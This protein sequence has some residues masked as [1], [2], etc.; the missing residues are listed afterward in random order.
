VEY[1]SNGI[2]VGMIAPKLSYAPTGRVLHAGRLGH[3]KNVDV[4][5]RAFARLLETLPDYTLDIVGD[6]PAR[7]NL[8]RL[9]RSLGIGQNVRMRGFMDR[10]S[11][12]RA[13]RDYDAFVTASTIE[14]QGIVLLEAMAAGLPVVGVD[15]LAIPEIVRDGRSGRIVAPGDEA[16]IA[17]ALAEVLGDQE[18]RARMGA[19]GREDVQPHLLPAVVDHLEELYGQVLEARKQ[20]R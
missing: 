7:P 15:A 9:I 18:A 17:T 3:E 11:L 13:Y 2:D 1:L 5:L 20:S 19:A 16:G 6:G 10:S 4:V 14:T 8:V 12:A